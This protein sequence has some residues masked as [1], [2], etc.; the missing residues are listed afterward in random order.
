MKMSEDADKLVA[1]AYLFTMKGDGVGYVAD[2]AVAVRGGH[3]AA[4]GPTSDLAAR[5]RASETPDTK[6]FGV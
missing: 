3:I 5:S 2:G 6:G 4:A 1:H